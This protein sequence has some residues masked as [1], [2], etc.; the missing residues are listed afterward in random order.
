MKKAQSRWEE[1]GSRV[2]G[3]SKMGEEMLVGSIWERDPEL[4]TFLGGVSGAR[5]AMEGD[6][7]GRQGRGLE[8][9]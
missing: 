1:C 8:W 6:E 5:V 9:R 3:L 7:D 4:K 2:T